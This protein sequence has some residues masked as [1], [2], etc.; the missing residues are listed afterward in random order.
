VRYEHGSILK[1]AEDV[2]DLGRLSASDTRANS[3]A[4]DCFDFAQP[5]RPFVPIKAPKGTDFFLR[6]IDDGRPPDYE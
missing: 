2:F 6:Q 1:F 4:S 5:P 3:P